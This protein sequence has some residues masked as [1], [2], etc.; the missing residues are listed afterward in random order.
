MKNFDNIHCMKKFFITILFMFMGTIS[1]SS[2]YD[3]I[4]INPYNLQEIVA[5]SYIRGVIA[6]G[7]VTRWN[8]NSFPLSVYVQTN[9]VPDYYVSAVKKAYMR[10]QS[11]TGGA[12]SFKFVSSPQNA[13]MKCYFTSDFGNLSED[14]VGYHQFKYMDDKIADSTIKFRLVDQNGKQFQNQVLYNVALHE[15][16]HSLGL[17]GHSSKSGDLMYPVSKSRNY[18][19]SKRDLT[20]L[21]LLYSMV[22]DNTDKPISA[23]EKSK[24]LT[25]AQVVG[26]EERLKQD[27]QTAARIN[28][29]ITPQDPSSRYRLAKAYQENKNYSQAIKEYKNVISM[30]D[31]TDLKVKLYA[32]IT[33]CY[34]SLKNYTAAQNCANYTYKKYPSRLSIVLLPTVQY[35]K[36]A[37]TDAVVRLCQIVAKDRD[38]EY[39]VTFLKQ[40][41]NQEKNNTKLKLS[42]IKALKEQN[43][44]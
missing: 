8:K 34:I 30:V 11:V 1:Y 33:S 44:I 23:S 32:E 24:L 42:I 27:A 39:A 22:P 21:K 2:P 20:T 16:G 31:S 41:Y 43:L 14:T 38:N 25:K 37:K 18:D 15:I 3:S 35:A 29:N 9:G 10:W 4:Y 36:G 6:Q 19:F 13:D 28:T 17:A 40:I 7:D 5:N 26:G 12:V